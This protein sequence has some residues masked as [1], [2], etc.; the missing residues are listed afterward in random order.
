MINSFVDQSK[1]GE[2]IVVTS[3]EVLIF[4]SEGNPSFKITGANITNVLLIDNYY[5][6]CQQNATKKVLVH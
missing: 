3:K 6:Y 1:E 4:D 5:W 2:Y